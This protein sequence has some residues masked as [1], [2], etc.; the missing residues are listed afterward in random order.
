M[1]EPVIES[2]RQPQP[3]AGQPR[4]REGSR[5]GSMPARLSTRPER[6]RLERRS[7]IFAG[8]D[9]STQSSAH[10]LARPPSVIL[11]AGGGGADPPGTPGGRSRDRGPAR[12]TP[13]S[14]GSV[15]PTAHR[16][17]THADCPTHVDRHHSPSASTHSSAGSASSEPEA[18][19]TEGRPI[20]RSPSG[21]TRPRPRPRP[22]PLNADGP[23]CQPGRVNSSTRGTSGRGGATRAEDP[24]A[25]VPTPPQAF[26][27]AQSAALC[28]F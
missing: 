8:F 20:A 25:G 28:P 9:T 3:D 15:H 5:R 22:S 24:R 12:S 7:F 2:P 13:T 18:S 26:G 27:F 16:R 21:E 19:T 11:A 6:F 10:A 23:S 4:E 14:P 17:V 1:S